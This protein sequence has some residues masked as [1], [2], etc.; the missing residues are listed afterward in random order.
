MVRVVELESGMAEV[1]GSLV[2]GGMW[3]V[4]FAKVEWN[5][6]LLSLTQ[7][8]RP[9]FT[10]KHPTY[11]IRSHR[12]PRVPW[13]VLVQHWERVVSIVACICGHHLTQLAHRSRWDFL[14]RWGH[15]TG[16]WGSHGTTFVY[17]SPYPIHKPDVFSKKVVLTWRTVKVAPRCTIEWKYCKKLQRV[18]QPL[19]RNGDWTTPLD[20]WIWNPGLMSHDRAVKGAKGPLRVQAVAMG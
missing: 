6:E 14:L 11:H 15:I 20:R 10:G 7:W 8:R 19:I 9:P 16:T 18:A 4:L 1:G 2:I 13:M 12:S 17:R 5:L 3:W